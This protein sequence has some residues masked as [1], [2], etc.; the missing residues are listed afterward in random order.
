MDISIII[1]SYNTKDV[2]R[3][4][5]DSIFQYTKDIEFEVIVVD[6][7]STDG[8]KEMLN[9][10]PDIKYIQSGGNIGFGKANNLGYKYCCGR[11]VLLLNSDT[12]LLNNAIKLFADA[13]DKLPHDVGCA[14]CKLK[15]SDGSH[16]HSFGLLPD[17]KETV[18]GILGLYCRPF[19]IRFKRFNERDYDDINQLEVEYVMGADL[20]IRREVVE[21]CGLFDPDFFMYYEESEMQYRY[22]TAGY[23]SVIVSG[24]EIVHL[25]CVSTKAD[26][27]KYSYRNRKMFF[28][29]YK[30]Y[31]KKRYPWYKYMLFRM[32]LVFQF[33]IFFASYYTLKESLSMIALLFTPV[34]PDIHE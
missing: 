23:K 27:K 1:I 8:S 15:S 14:G 34:R 5:L 31:M 20:C 12:Y 2:T 4:C 26:G 9:S 13:F 3:Q 18:Y 21:Q 7:G 16:N 19:G 33:P 10:Y 6:N 24:P 17:L 29:S 11:Y 32:I 25:E 28:E 30:L 22:R